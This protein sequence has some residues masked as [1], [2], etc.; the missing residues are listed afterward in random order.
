MK[1]KKILK[2][3]GPCWS[4]DTNSQLVAL[5]IHK[6]VEIYNNEDQLLRTMGKEQLSGNVWDVSF[7]DN[8][9]ILATDMDSNDIKMFTLQGLFIR[10]IGRGSST[11]FQ[12]R[13]IAVSPDGHIYVCDH[14]NHCVCVFDVN[15]K[16]LSSFG[17]HGSGDECFNE[18][19]DLCFASDGFL[20]ISDTFNSRIS[21]Y[22]SGI[23]IGKFTTV[24][25]PACIAATDCGHLV[26]GSGWHKIMIYT[27]GGDLVH[28]FGEYGVNEGQFNNP[29]GVS[30]DS[31]G[32]IYIVDSGNHRIQ[33]Y[34]L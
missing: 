14:A 2:Y 31:D 33:L 1:F 9:N 25:Y 18:P 24:Y 28:E 6:H 29:S 11:A 19:T 17:S 21:V 22:D 26:V 13:G 5:G 10:T 16:F 30:V 7:H 20:Y 23:F 3:T 4:V 12:P 32:R 27:T 8:C 15:G 34:A